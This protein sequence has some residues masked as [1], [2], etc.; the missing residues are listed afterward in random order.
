MHSLF[1][2]SIILFIL[3]HIKIDIY[4]VKDHHNTH[5]TNFTNSTNI[6]PYIIPTNKV[7]HYLTFRII[8]Y[9]IEE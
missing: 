2:L 4:N 9:V 3:S 7:K 1:I 6:I 5:S 8:F